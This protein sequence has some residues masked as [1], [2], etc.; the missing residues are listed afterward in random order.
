MDKEELHVD[1]APELL[2]AEIFKLRSALKGP[3]GFET[4]YDAAVHERVRRVK[5]EKNAMRYRAVRWYKDARTSEFSTECDQYVDR[6]LE[7]LKT[8]VPEVYEKL[9]NEITE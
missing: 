5:A 8:V 1:A 7:H 3:E 2:W 9:K 4:W 6:Y